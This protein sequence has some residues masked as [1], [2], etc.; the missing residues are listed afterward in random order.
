MAPP[1]I[2]EVRCA[3]EIF[4]R[5]KRVLPTSLGGE[6]PPVV[7]VLRLSG[8]IGA[9]GG[10]RPGLTAH[11]LDHAIERAFA[12]KR[13]VAVAL[14]VNSPGGAPVQSALI[15]SRIR[16][17]ATEKKIPVIAFAEDVAASG[18]YWLALAGD[19]I[20]A[21]ANSIVGSIGVISAGFGFQDAI[22]RI[23]VE[24]RLYTSGDR[25]SLLDSFRVAEPE[26]VARLKGL[27]AEIHESFK[28]WVRAR[29]GDRLKAD[30]ATAF[31][32]E[33]WT[34]ATALS[35]GLIDGVGDLRT[36][37]KA[38]FGDK[39]RLRPVSTER[40]GLLRRLGFGAGFGMSLGANGVA[41][42]P[43]AAIDAIE[44]RAAW[45]RFGL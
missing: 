44:D 31:S 30:E 33:A 11:G 28:A 20:Y 18:G 14:V 5:L 29:R 43:A 15:A 19:D 1:S 37:L 42:L 10:L 24:R 22:A 25:K 8:V 27:Q 23:G 35:L 26:D 45:S 13:Q 34:G 12:P 17:L 38:R 32:G 21:D 41:A 9:F 2:F 7:S 36:V 3:M 6:R 39:V 16:A 4:D 40:P